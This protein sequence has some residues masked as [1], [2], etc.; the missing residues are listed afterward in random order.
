[1]KCT[2]FRLVV[3]GQKGMEGD[4]SI[5]RGQKGMEDEV[6]VKSVIFL[7]LYKLKYRKQIRSL[8]TF[9]KTRG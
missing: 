5:S 9:V 6:L 8:L 3:R 2:S 7:F 1:M 4:A